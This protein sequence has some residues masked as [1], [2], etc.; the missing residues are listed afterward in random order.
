VELLSGHPSLSVS[1]RQQNPSPT[2]PGV[3]EGGGVVV[4]LGVLVVVLGVLVVVPSVLVVVLGVLLVV[5][6]VL[7]VVLGVLLV[8][9]GVLV[10]KIMTKPRKRKL[11]TGQ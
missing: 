1:G 8:V 6:G 4:V 2:K 9:P 11:E 10:S 5:P 7:V 3:Q